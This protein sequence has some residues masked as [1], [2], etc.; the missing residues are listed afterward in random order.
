MHLTVVPYMCL[1]VVLHIEHAVLWFRLYQLIST[2]E[3]HL[4]GRKGAATVRC[5]NGELQ[6]YFYIFF[7]VLKN[8]KK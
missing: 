7:I 1:T 3:L 4:V 2:T 6:S 8:S 5:L